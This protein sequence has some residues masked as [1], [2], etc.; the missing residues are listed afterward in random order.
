MIGRWG[1]VA[2]C[3]LG[4]LLL[5]AAPARAAEPADGVYV[6]GAL[7]RLHAE[8]PAFGFQDLKRLMDVLQPQVLV[9]E[10][11]PDEL[12]GRLETQGRPE[13]PAVVWPWLAGREVLVVAMEPGGA[14]FT[15]ITSAAGAEISAFHA[16]DPKGAAEWGRLRPAVETALRAHWRHPADTQ[17][18]VTAEL[19]RALAISDVA[20]VGAGFGAVQAEWDGYMLAQARAAVTAYPGKRILVLGSYRNRAGLEVG[21]RPVAGRRLVDVEAWLRGPA[22]PAPAKSGDDGR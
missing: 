20:L 21:L 16:R 14:E 7:H 6:V 10:V 9:L 1:R 2:G 3:W 15:R 4:L 18:P 8:E 11:R 17:D 22:F 13:Y 5:A 19:A 12:D